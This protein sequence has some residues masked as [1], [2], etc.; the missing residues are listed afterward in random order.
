MFTYWA[1]P[2]K[3]LEIKPLSEELLFY[4]DSKKITT[5]ND[6][7]QNA[8]DFVGQKGLFLDGRIDPPLAGVKI[9]VVANDG[10]IKPITLETPSSGR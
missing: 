8:V 2:H 3:T 9:T 4:P 6:C 1:A 7:M 5:L 10:S